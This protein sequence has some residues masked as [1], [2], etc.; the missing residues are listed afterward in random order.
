[1]LLAGCGLRQGIL[2]APG[3]NEIFPLPERPMMSQAP[4][5]R[6]APWPPD[7]VSASRPALGRGELQFTREGRRFKGVHPLRIREARSVERIIS[8]FFYCISSQLCVMGA[9]VKK[10]RWG[11]FQYEQ[12]KF[13]YREKGPALRYGS[14]PPGCLSCIGSADT[15]P[16]KIEFSQYFGNRI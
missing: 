8:S 1:M 16:R 4:E 13:S 11:I 12:E 15:S 5:T 2:Q 7:C 6:I 9:V 14:G 10:S 3:S